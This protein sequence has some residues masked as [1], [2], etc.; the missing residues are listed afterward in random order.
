MEQLAHTNVDDWIPHRGTMQLLDRVMEAD[1]DGAV[2]EVD[3]AA[4]SAFLRGG[5]V[6]AW[7]GIEYMAQT[8][9]AWSGGRARRRGDGRPRIGL[10]LG[11]RRYLAHCQGFPIGATLR[12]QAH[13]E[14]SGDNGLGLFD[15]RIT[16][17]GA[18]LAEAKISVLEPEDATALLRPGAGA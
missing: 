10:L 12:V 5:Q 13:C 9:S 14:L 18:V 17:A 15:C 8:I 1:E 6:P 11:S 3:I 2:A 16:L 4:T 7:I